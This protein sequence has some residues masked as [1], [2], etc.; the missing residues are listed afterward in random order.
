MRAL[1]IAV[2]VG[3]VGCAADPAAQVGVPYASGPGF[4]GVYAAPSYGY[5]PAPYGSVGY[6]GSG[7]PGPAYVPPYAGPVVVGPGPG[8]G[9]GGFE[10]DR[11]WRER[12]G[13]EGAQR[14]QELQHRAGQ[15]R[16][17]E[18]QRRD[19]RPLAGPPVRPAPETRPPHP[20]PVPRGHGPE[21]RLPPDWR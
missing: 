9:G 14:E 16:A 8:F 12:L 13:R 15:Q 7:Y 18:Q 2:A 3:L 4:G 20:E 19:I 10:R 11:L 6:G 1:L 5:A 21:F 17:E